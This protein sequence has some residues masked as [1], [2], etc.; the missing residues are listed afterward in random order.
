MNEL[1]VNFLVISGKVK[2]SEQKKWKNVSK[3]SGKMLKTV[4]KVEK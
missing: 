2:K 1:N 4:K 3:K